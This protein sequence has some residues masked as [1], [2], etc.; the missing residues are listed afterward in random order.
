MGRILIFL[1]GLDWRVLFAVPVLAVLLGVLNNFNK[2]MPDEQRVVWSGERPAADGEGENAASGPGGGGKPGAEVGPGT[3]KTGAERGEWTS[4][5]D[6]ATNAAEAAHV[7]VV[8]VVTQKGCAYCVRLHKVLKSVAVSSWMKERDWYFVM[9]TRESAP[10]VAEYVVTT[11]VTNTVAPYVGVYWTRGDGNRVMRNFPGRRSMMGVRKENKL[12]LEWMRAVEKSLSGAPG[13][14]KGASAFSIVRGAKLKIAAAAECEGGAEGRVKMS[15]RV[16][17]LKEG[18]S[19]QLT[20]EPKSGSVL[21][22]WRYPNGRTV[23]GK[24]R[25]TVG[26]HNPEGTYTAVFRRPENCAG[27]VLQLPEGELEWEEWKSEKLVLRVNEDAYPVTFS[28]SGLP[29]GMYLSSRTR[30]LI[31]GVPQTNGVFRIEV[32]VKGASSRLPA[33]KGAFTVRVKPMDRKSGDDEDDAGKD[34]DDDEVD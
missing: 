25:L 21:A 4:N 7:P 22:G 16:S 3:G 2:Q 15:P 12:A 24:T 20:A 10:E 33:A 29:Y 19:V 14:E 31:A 6:A 1:K 5:F 32:A 30:G 27:P 17:F 23:H 11:P 9:T 18:Q 34:D 13:L 28:C 8:V 26:S